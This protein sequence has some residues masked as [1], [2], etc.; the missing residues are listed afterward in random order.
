M[1]DDLV[2]LERVCGLGGEQCAVHHAA[3]QQLVGL[4]GWLEGDVHVQLFGNLV[5]H[6]ATDAELQTG[7]VFN[8]GD[9][10]FGV[11]ND[12]GAMRK[13]GQYFDALVFSSEFRVLAGHAV[14]RHRDGLCLVAQE[15]QFGHLRQ[16]ETTWGIAV[17]G[18]GDIHQSVFDGIKSPGWRGDCT[19]QDVATDPVGGFA[20]KGVAPLFLRHRQAVSR[21]NPA[22][23]GEYCLCLCQA[24]PQGK[25]HEA[26]GDKGFL[27][28]MSPLNWLQ[29]II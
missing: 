29:N 3:G 11:E 5:H 2:D 8:T 21:R 25:A 22:R 13:V 27:H 4:R 24:S 18:E 19:G 15:G 23:S 10:T 16:H 20:G 9:R 1:L 12:P 17:H 6:A 26:S 14:E 28:C 7:E